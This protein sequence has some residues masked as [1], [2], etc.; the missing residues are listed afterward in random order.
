MTLVYR[1]Y[2]EF[3]IK[4][5]VKKVYI[6]Q[7]VRLT[8][9]T[10][11]SKLYDAMK[12]PKIFIA[13]AHGMVG[14][15]LVRAY[16]ARGIS[17]L[18]TPH[19]AELDLLDQAKVRSYLALH[20]PETLIIAAAKVGG[21]LANQSF[22]A[23]FLYENLVIATNLIGGAHLEGIQR[24]LFLGSSCIYP[25]YAEQPIREESLL[26]APLEPTNEA[27]ALA[28]IAGVKLCEFYT[29]QYGRKYISAMPTNLYGPGDNYHKT[30]SHVIPGLIRRFHEAKINGDKEVAIWGSGTPLREFLYVDD[31]AEASLFLLDRY[32]GSHIN[33]GSGEELSIRELAEIVSQVIGYK[34][35]ITNDLSKPDGTPRKKVDLSKLEALGW[36]AKTK[37]ALG[38]ERAYIDFQISC[39]R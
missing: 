9:K 39:S 29:K 33:I 12:K 35:F 38:L 18:L 2:Y 5:K 14:K 4:K 34:G 19:R 11:F 3:F 30:H 17:D 6:Y 21:I 10:H 24:V 22:P 20:R 8:A 26:S 28:K 27:Y 13:G 25:K 16:Q 31:L 7:C 36:R 1:N 23:D 32:E 37:L 15:A